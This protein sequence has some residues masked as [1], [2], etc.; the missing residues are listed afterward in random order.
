VTIPGDLNGDYTVGL[1]D[2]VVLAKA[3]GSEP[4]NPNWNP[5]ADIDDNGIVGLS[6][7]VIMAIHYGQHYP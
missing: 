4:V 1:A 2:L 6:D 5:N 7:L 3:Y